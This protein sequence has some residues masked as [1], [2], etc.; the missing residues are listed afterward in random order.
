MVAA[1]AD[2]GGMRWARRHLD[3]TWPA[4][5]P[6]W[7]L[8]VSN[9]SGELLGACQ[10]PVP[11]PFELIP[12]I[13]PAMRCHRCDSHLPSVAIDAQ[14]TE[15]P[16][17]TPRA[18]SPPNGDKRREL[19]AVRAIVA[20]GRNALLKTPNPG[21]RD[22]IRDRVPELLGQLEEA[23]D[24]DGADAEVL[25]RLDEARRMAWE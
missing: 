24:R 2:T 6:R 23:L 9:T 3:L 16:H 11:P 22:R 18:V 8:I 13:P 4:G 15:W 5:G 1:W 17:D 12:Q 25:S 14:M 19:L 20:S 7:H 10:R 21:E